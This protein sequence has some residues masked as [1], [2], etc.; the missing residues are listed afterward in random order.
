MEPPQLA[1]ARSGPVL[2]ALVLRLFALCPSVQTGP[3]H[4]ARTQPADRELLSWLV[5]KLPRVLP[6]LL[7]PVRALQAQFPD[8]AGRR[9]EPRGQKARFRQVALSFFAWRFH[10]LCED[11]IS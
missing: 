8:P 7:A 3:A 5:P 11:W 9:R 1:V 10:S 2:H 4:G 6:R